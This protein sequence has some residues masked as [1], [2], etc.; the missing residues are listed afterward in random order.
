LNI[1]FIRNFVVIFINKLKEKHLQSMKK[2]LKKLSLLVALATVFA[3]AFSNAQAQDAA[4][5]ESKSSFLIGV[6]GGLTVNKML[7]SHDWSAT[8]Y[9]SGGQ[10]LAFAHLNFNSWVGTALEVG[11][12]Q[13]GASRFATE[14]TNGPR[15]TDYRLSNVQANLL[16]YF[17]LPVLSVYEP[18]IFIGP[19]MDANVYATGNVEGMT[20][21]GTPLKYRVDATNNFKSMDWAMIVG[22]GVDFDIKFATLMIDARYRHGIT[23]VN[24]SYG[25]GDQ[26]IS[27]IGMGN[28]D[29]RTRGWAINIGLGF[30]I[31]K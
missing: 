9:Y 25:L 27:S 11:F 16:T 31:G 18:K 30:K 24:N 2:G 10:A 7:V 20:A 28:N 29:V 13:S 15:M 22:L 5:P 23:D 1:V 26:Y 12:S 21:A 19:S 4:K 8:N 6:K 14:A 17:K 3:F